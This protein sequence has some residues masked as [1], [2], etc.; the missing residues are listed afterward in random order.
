MIDKGRTERRSTRLT[1][2]AG[3]RANSGA[4][5]AESH[6]DSMAD[7]SGRGLATTP[8]FIRGLIAAANS[9]SLEEFLDKTYPETAPEAQ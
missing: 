9:D 7:L 5:R 8:E 4:T 3:E 6:L 2:L 1:T